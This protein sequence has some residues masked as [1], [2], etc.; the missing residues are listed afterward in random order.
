MLGESKCVDVL[1]GK[2]GGW[3]NEP[4]LVGKHGVI[5]P[6]MILCTASMTYLAYTTFI[7]KKQINLLP[8]KKSA[9]RGKKKAITFMA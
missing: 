6:L 1:V 3:E 5:F 2:T 7:S 4:L 9:Q 8:F